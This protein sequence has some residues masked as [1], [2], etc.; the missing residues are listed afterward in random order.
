MLKEVVLV[1]RNKIMFSE[2][3]ELQIIHTEIKMS[4]KRLL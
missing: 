4:A 1:Q 3:I 2:K